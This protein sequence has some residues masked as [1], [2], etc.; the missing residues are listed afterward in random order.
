MKI[1]PINYQLFSFMVSDRDCKPS[2]FAHKRN[3]V[4]FGPELDF[5]PNLVGSK[6]KALW[7]NF[8]LW[9]PVM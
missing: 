8:L 4:A 6:I 5:L 9:E 1:K 3:W 2:K 7:I